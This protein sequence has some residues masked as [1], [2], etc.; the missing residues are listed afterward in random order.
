[1]RQCHLVKHFYGDLI[2]V[3]HDY[4]TV[5]GKQRRED[6][7]IWVGIR[8]TNL[9]NFYIYIGS[10]EVDTETQ[11]LPGDDGRCT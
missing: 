9:P 8:D 4:I 7:S 5:S 1:M 6:Q 3:L 11:A 2:E 10:I